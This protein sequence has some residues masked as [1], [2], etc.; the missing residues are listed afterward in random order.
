[1]F[2]CF[3]IANEGED[4]PDAWLE[5]PRSW[6]KLLLQLVYGRHIAGRWHYETSVETQREPLNPAAVQVC[7]SDFVMWYVRHSYEV[8]T[9]WAQRFFFWSVN[10]VG[11]PSAV[12]KVSDLVRA[13]VNYISWSINLMVRAL[14]FACSPL[15]DVYTAMWP[16]LNRDKAAGHEKEEEGGAEGE[17][18]AFMKRV[19]AAAGLLGVYVAWAL[20]SWFIFTYGM[21]IYRQMGDQA[22]KKFTQSWGVNFGVSSAQEWQDVAKEAL[23]TTVILIILDLLLILGNGPW[24]EEHLDHLSMQATLFT[25]T[26]TSWFG[27][28]MRMVQQQKRL[29]NE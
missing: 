20:Y 17:E 1:L 10:V 29:C 19:Y 6:L 15:H 14:R 25:G 23:K 7:R 18:D 21:L 22:Q 4:W 11:G 9:L 2:R 3:E 24:L 8:P 5:L 27:R 26:A 28:T 16:P 13:V 12:D